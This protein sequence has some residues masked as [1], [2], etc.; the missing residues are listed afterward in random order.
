MSLDWQS[1]IEQL[2]TMARETRV[3]EAN[4]QIEEILHQ[5][6]EVVG[7]WFLLSKLL[8]GQDLIWEERIE[9]ELERFGAAPARAY[10]ATIH[11]LNDAVRGAQPEETPDAAAANVPQVVEEAEPEPLE[12]E[13]QAPVPCVEA[14]EAP[15][16]VVL[17][18]DQQRQMWRLQGFLG[19]L[20]V[21]DFTSKTRQ[22]Q[23]SRLK[24]LLD[25]VKDY[26]TQRG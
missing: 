18:E 17:N 20:Y 15:S 12:T 11:T 9:K 3:E 8:A 26:R 16:P 6:P 13:R 24:G 21:Y 5:Y 2:A 10:R 25:K 19:R 14:I 4:A 23:D 22:G 1:T 7:Q